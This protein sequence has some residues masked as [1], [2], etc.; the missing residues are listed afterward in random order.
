MFVDKLPLPL[1][2]PV[3]LVCHWLKG[4]ATF[5]LCNNVHEPLAVPLVAIMES[6]APFKMMPVMRGEDGGKTG[7]KANS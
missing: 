2:V 5:V 3:Q 7:G 4:S 6:E 1:K